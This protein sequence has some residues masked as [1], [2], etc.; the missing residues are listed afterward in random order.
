MTFASAF[1]IVLALVAATLAVRGAF[2]G[3]SGEFFSLLGM[4]G[5]VILAWNYAA[6]PARWIASLWDGASEALLKVISM[7]LIYILAVLLAN[8]ACRGVKAFIKFA[9]LT[10]VDRVL[11]VLSGLLK[12]VFL[13]LFLYVGI[14]TYSPFLPTAWIGDSLV[15]RQADVLWP[16]IQSMLESWKIFPK[17]FSLPELHLPDLSSLRGGGTTAK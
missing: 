15:M 10:M 9:S 13:I 17:D 4:V 2:R 11:G 7:V 14:T 6:F 1:D 5:G 12:A 8:L 3:F 16:D